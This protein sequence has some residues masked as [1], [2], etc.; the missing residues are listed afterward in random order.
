MTRSDMRR[1]IV[2][3][4]KQHDA[5][6]ISVFGSFARGE[7]TEESDIDILVSFNRDISFLDLV[8]LELEL[9]DML[10]KKVDLVMEGGVNPMLKPYIDRDIEIIY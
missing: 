8:G 2:D 3:F 6:R 10:G 1:V 5:R 9:S 4:L 7:E